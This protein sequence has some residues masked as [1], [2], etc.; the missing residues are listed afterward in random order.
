V[1]A[2]AVSSLLKGR[3]KG[4]CPC[5]WSAKASSEAKIS[6]AHF[7]AFT[8][9]FLHTSTGDLSVN[10]SLE[11]GLQPPS[12]ALQPAK[13]SHGNCDAGADHY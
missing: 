7:C 1:A 3:L 11:L 12:L 8:S 13:Q 4:A 2:I 6:M 5:G 9:A 10:F